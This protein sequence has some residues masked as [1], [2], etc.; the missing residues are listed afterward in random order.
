[1]YFESLWVMCPLTVWVGLMGGGAYVNVMHEILEL[2]ALDKSEKESA[3]SLTLFFNN[4]GIFLAAIFSLLLDN[5]IFDP[6][7][8]KT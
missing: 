7:N 3:I 8:I 2:E 6:S 1:M 5:T 4:F